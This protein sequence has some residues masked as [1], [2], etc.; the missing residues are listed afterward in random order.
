MCLSVINQ[1]TTAAYHC[2]KAFYIYDDNDF[3]INSFV[4]IRLGLARVVDWSVLSLSPV[5]FNYRNYVVRVKSI[6]L[7]RNVNEMRT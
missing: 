2:L 3:I 1:H 7:I 6:D 4:V 5:S